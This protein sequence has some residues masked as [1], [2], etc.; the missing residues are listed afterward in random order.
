MASQHSDLVPE[1]PGGAIHPWAIALVLTGLLI[2]IGLAFI[3]W[4][5]ND[6][7]T[8]Q[9]F[10]RNILNH[11]ILW[12]YHNNK[13]FNHPPIPGYVAAG[14]YWVTTGANPPDIGA[15]YIG[16]SFPFVFKM[17]DVA[18]DA[19]TCLLLW[20]ILQLRQGIRFASIAVCL[21]A[22]SPCS[23]LLTGHHCNTDPIYVMLCLLC[24][25]LVE[26]RGFDF[27]GGL[28]WPRRLM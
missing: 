26:D 9:I 10:G 28:A 19:V 13:D 2:R 7:T 20:K 8:W 17:F 18:A 12:L 16:F 24:V 27:L 23:I 15:R 1:S 14:I 21:F 5:S 25:W 4:G 11:G 3:S 22:W 6:A